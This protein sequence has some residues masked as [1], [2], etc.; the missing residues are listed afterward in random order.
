LVQ[1]SDEEET[2]QCDGTTATVETTGDGVSTVNADTTTGISQISGESSGFAIT[3]QVDDTTTG[4]SQISGESPGF[5]MRACLNAGAPI[6]VEWDGATRGF[7][8]GFGLCSP[9]RWKP[10]QRGA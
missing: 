9:T 1:D 6:Q 10:R 2:T 5:D 7:I 4:I 3:G 8:D